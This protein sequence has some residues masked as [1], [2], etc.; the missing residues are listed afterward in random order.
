MYRRQAIQKCNGK[1]DKWSLEQHTRSH[2]THIGRRQCLQHTALDPRQL[3]KGQ[4]VEIQLANASECETSKVLILL[5][6]CFA[7][8]V[9]FRVY[10]S[11]LGLLGVFR[12]AEIKIGLCYVPLGVNQA[13]SSDISRSW[14]HLLPRFLGSPVTH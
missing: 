5:F 11:L 10:G 7:S 1:S 2:S 4:D 3:G 6:N 8:F 13:S 9:F 14:H 12:Y